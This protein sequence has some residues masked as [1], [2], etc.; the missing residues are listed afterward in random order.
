MFPRPFIDYLI[1]FHCFKD[2]FECHEVLEE[3]WKAEGRKNRLWVSFIQ[4]AVAMYHHRRGNFPGAKKQITRAISIVELEKAQ[5]CQ[6]G[7]SVDALVSLLIQKK[8]E[9]GECKSYS[10]MTFPIINE[11]LINQC[12]IKA[13]EMGTNWG[14]PKHLISDDIIHKHKLRDRSAIIKERILQLNKKRRD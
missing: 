6:L 5:V 10:P 12:E 13:K 11:K 1:Y 8:D 9:I 7:I 14:E 2:Y 4:I 3:H